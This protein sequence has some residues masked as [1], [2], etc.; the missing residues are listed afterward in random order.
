VYSKYYNKDWSRTK[1]YRILKRMR[2]KQEEYPCKFQN[3]SKTST[4]TMS[5]EGEK[6]EQVT[7]IDNQYKNPKFNV[8]SRAFQCHICG[9][10]LSWK[11]EKSLQ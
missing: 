6:T 5:F 1:I 9:S 11:S 10:G 8:E 7:E 2:H 4:C 3:E